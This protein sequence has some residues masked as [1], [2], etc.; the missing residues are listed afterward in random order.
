MRAVIETGSKQ[1]IVEEGTILDIE[2]LETE[3]K[4]VLFDRV[5]AVFNAN[6]IKLGQPYIEGARVEA[7]IL[8]QIRA[9]KIKVFKFKRKTGYQKTQG[10]RQYLTTIKVEKISAA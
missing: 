9:D 1:Y 4:T 8:N 10:H 3:E 6:D 2:K 5:L 7:T